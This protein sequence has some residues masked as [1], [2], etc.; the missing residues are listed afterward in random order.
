MVS[1]MLF[2]KRTIEGIQAGQITLA[3]RVWR[4]PTVKAGGRLR[5][6]AGEL[7]IDAVERISPGEISDADAR[8]A[9][10]ADRTALLADLEGRNGELYRIAFRVAGPD[11]R[12][13]LASDDVLGP[14]DRAAIAAMLSGMDRNS[15]DGPWTERWLNLI[16]RFPET[17]VA[18][19]AVH[20]NVTKPLFKSRVRRL[21]ELGLTESLT[22]GYRLTPRGRR[23]CVAGSCAARID[24]LSGDGC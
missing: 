24:V 10:A 7:A 23:Y 22:V 3:F 5:T 19:L 12:L 17:P 16:A 9:G 8:A 2:S 6:P 20:A 13:A 15:A 21:K 11:A 1:I 18:R 4:R 14:S